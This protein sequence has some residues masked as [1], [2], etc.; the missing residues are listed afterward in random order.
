MLILILEI[1]IAM[2]ILKILIEF[3]LNDAHTIEKFGRFDVKNSYVLK[4]SQTIVLRS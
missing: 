2:V 3:S 1:F 4:L